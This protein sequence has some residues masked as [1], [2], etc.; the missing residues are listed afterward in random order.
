MINKGLNIIFTD[1]IIDNAEFGSVE[2]GGALNIKESENISVRGCHI[3]NPKLRGIFI[4]KSSNVQ[5]NSCF[6]T[7]D[8][9][10]SQMLTSLE[11]RDSCPGTVIR[12]NMLISGKKGDI[13]NQAKGAVVETNNKINSL[14]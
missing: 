5:V 13:I 1:N 10:N 8:K 14:P 9:T 4:E 2:S 11:L 3:I 7:K 12:D 6:V